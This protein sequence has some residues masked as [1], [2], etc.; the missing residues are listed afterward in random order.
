MNCRPMNRVVQTNSHENTDHR[1]NTYR[2]NG[3]ESGKLKGHRTHRLL[4]D[5]LVSVIRSFCYT[6]AM[7]YANPRD[8]LAV[9]YRSRLE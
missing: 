9:I 4:K 1:R 6:Y 2:H 5:G 7:L 3:K 8:L